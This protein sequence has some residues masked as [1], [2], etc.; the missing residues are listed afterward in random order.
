MTEFIDLISALV[1]SRALAAWVQAIGVIA[2]LLFGVL[3][4]RE[5]VAFPH[6][7]AA[8]DLRDR[9]VDRL[10][11][12]RHRTPQEVLADLDELSGALGKAMGRINERFLSTQ[13]RRQLRAVSKVI[14]DLRGDIER[15]G[16]NQPDAGERSDIWVAPE[17]PDVGFPDSG[18]ALSAFASRWTGDEAI[19]RLSWL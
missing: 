11:A 15:L 7:L 16:R 2:V 8:R 5:Q 10:P 13:E 9:L 4:Y 18:A 12:L 19:R 17:A 3:I 1:Q 6:R 14:A